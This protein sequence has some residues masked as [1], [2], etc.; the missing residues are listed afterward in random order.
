MTYQPGGRS[1]PCFT[2]TVPAFLNGD[3]TPRAFLERC[4]EVLDAREATL[5]AFVC[6]DADAAREAADDA[7]DRY[8]RNEVLS[9]LDGCPVGI[10]DII[11]TKDFPTQMGSP[12]FKDWQGRRDAACVQALRAGGAVIL[13]KTVTTEFAFGVPGPTCNPYDE[14]RTP[15]GSSSGSAA[16]VGSGMLPLALG[17]QTGGSVLRPASYCANVGFKPSHGALNLG[18]VHPISPSHDHLGTM[19]G[20]LEDAWAAAHFIS[21]AA[22]G[23]GDRPCFPGD[24]TLPS[25]KMPERLIRLDTVAWPEIDRATKDAF[26]TYLAK[27]EAAGVEILD[28][29]SDDGIAALETM[30][31]EVEQFGWDVTAYEARWPFLGYRETGQLS[32]FIASRMDRIT[33]MSPDDFHSAVAKR[34]ALRHRAN[35][36]A[37]LSDGYITLAASGAA[38]KG[39]EETGSRKFLLPWSI[40][41]GPAYS[42]PLLAV[43]EMPLGVQLMGF[44]GQDTDLTAVARWM[45]Q[46]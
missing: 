44:H 45:M 33:G 27:L 10:K 16:A 34:D 28:K 19:A 9:P 6:L 5:K 26:E 30:L 2:T 7:T 46:A 40:V 11:E 32:D 29:D 37:E 35:S 14:T 43:D 36:L 21:V 39:L 4:L 15:G 8:K 25:A 13:G 17:S 41:G 31:T 23:S 38:P 18:G 42:L 1:L 20:T 24:G 3:D 22:G 12:I